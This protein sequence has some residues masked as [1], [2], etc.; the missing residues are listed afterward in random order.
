LTGSLKEMVR[1][2][3]PESAWASARRVKLRLRVRRYRRRVVTHRYGQSELRV[4]IADE[5]GAGWYD[6]DWP[7]PPELSVFSRSSLRPG[8]RVFDLGAH[9]GVVALML[10]RAVQ[11]GGVVVAVE[12]T[13]HNAQVAVENVRLNAPAAVTVVH[14]AVTDTP[15]S[16]RA[17][18]DLNASVTAQSRGTVVRAVTVDGLAHEHGAPDLVYVDVEGHECHALR[19]AAE[20]LA[21]R[22]DWFIEV[23][24]QGPLQAAGGSVEELLEFLHGYRLLVML[25]GESGFRPLPERLPDDRFFLAALAD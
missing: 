9:Q 22:P 3:V 2:V 7:E 8:A 16:A 18:F 23:H 14:A 21:A 20:A 12:L 17:D 1:N 6:H 13:E 25:E 10:E 5:L 4:M 19:G 24:A 11:P 15:G